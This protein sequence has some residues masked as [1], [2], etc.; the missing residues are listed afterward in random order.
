MIE[1]IQIILII[2]ILFALS[3]VLLRYNE[4]KVSTLEFGFWIVIWIAAIIAI[5]L[6]RTVGYISKT[7]GI[8][9]PAD[10][11]LYIAVILL[12]YL[13]FRIYVAIDSLEHNMTKIAREVAIKKQKRK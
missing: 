12:F 11:I 7:F 3:R 5:A 4:G 1:A 10:L 13:V 9:R 8:G 2:F 6:P